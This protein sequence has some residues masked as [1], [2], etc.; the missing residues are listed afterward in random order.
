MIAR[1]MEITQHIAQLLI[2]KIQILIMVLLHGQ[3]TIQTK[4]QLKIRL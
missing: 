1:N 2:D 3:V 4:E